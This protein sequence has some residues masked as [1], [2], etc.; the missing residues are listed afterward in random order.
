MGKSIVLR[1]P[2][3]EVGWTVIELQGA[4]ESRVGGSLDGVQFG[5]LQREPGVR[6]SPRESRR[7]VRAT[8]PL[9]PTA[10]PSRAR[11]ARTPS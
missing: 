10:V 7:R 8:R 11:E 5:R 6:P 1:S 4:I 3:G 2:A 9:P